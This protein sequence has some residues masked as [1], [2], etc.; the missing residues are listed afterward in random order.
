MLAG[1]ET[2]SQLVTF[3]A[4]QYY[5]PQCSISDRPRFK[6]RGFLVDTAR[7]YQPL[8]YLYQFLVSGGV[9]VGVRLGAPEMGRACP[10]VSMLYH[11][12]SCTF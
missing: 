4:G 7:H 5:L 2:F 6:Y 3:E 10:P 8:K 1:L 11:I 9:D 12:T